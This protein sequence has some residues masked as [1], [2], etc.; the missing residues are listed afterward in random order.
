MARL[1][2]AVRGHGAIWESL[3]E[4]VLADRLPHAL[5]FV[6]PSGIGKRGV[7]WALAQALVCDR[8]SRP[9]GE[10]PSCLRVEKH[11]S[12]C[13]LALEPDG[14]Q[15]KLAAAHRIL[16]FLSFRA[17][18]RAR[19]VLVDDAHQMNPQAANSILKILEEPPPGTHFLLIAPEVTQLL[20]TLRSRTQ[21]IRFSPLSAA[22]LA[23]V[24]TAEDWMLKSAR[25]SVARL[26]VLRDES[27][28]ELRRA[29]LAF[30]RACLE[31]DRSGVRALLEVATD[32]ETSV[33]VA[34]FLQQELRDWL[35]LGTGMELH[36]DLTGE[37]ASWRPLAPAAKVALWRHARQIEVDIDSHL[38]R[39][40]LFE[41]F[42]YRAATF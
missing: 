31:K 15:I 9:C 27:A 29:C 38:D 25:G 30:L 4:R 18:G 32:R 19:V 39:T 10:C 41:N 34:R 42:F 37:L 33:K 12:E 5:V 1:I 20:P 16:E 23:E 21:V 8:E 6:G 22:E 26:D 28:D 11:Q 40:L 35:V 14:P 3:M 13:V 36:G 17:W 24:A 2:D 7:A